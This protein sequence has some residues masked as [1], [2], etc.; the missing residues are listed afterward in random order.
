MTVKKLKIHFFVGVLL[1]GLIHAWLL[2]NVLD[3]DGL[4]NLDMGDGF[5]QGDRKA[6]INGMWSP[7]YPILLGF[8]M[9]LFK[10]DTYWESTVVHFVNFLIYLLS[11]F[12][13][14]FFLSQ[15]IK[16]Q[17]ARNTNVLPEWL[18]I[19]F[20]YVLFLWSSLSL[21]TVSRIMPDMLV[22]A[23]VYLIFGILLK[24]KQE[25][26]NYST[27]IL[28]GLVLGLGYLSKSSMF[29]FAFI[30]LI[31]CLFEAKDHSRRVKYTFISFVVFC[32]VSSPYIFLL[33]KYKGH[34][35]PGESGKVNY[36]WEVNRILEMNEIRDCNMTGFSQCDKLVHPLRELLR[37]PRVMEYSTPFN[38]TYPP[39]HDP[40]YW[41]EGLVPQLDLYGLIQA[42]KRNGK[43]YINLFSQM[44]WI[45][46]AYFILFFMSSNKS[47]CLRNIKNEYTLLVPVFVTVLLYSFIH[48]EPRYVAPFLVVFWLGLFSAVKLPDTNE[49]IKSAHSLMCILIVLMSFV[50]LFSSELWD[51]VCDN[52]A[53]LEWKVSEAIKKEANIKAGDKVAVFPGQGY[54]YWARYAKAR[55]V[56]EIR[57]EDL[58]DFWHATSSVQSD[59]FKKLKDIGVK[60][61]VA[62]I[63][64][65]DTSIPMTSWYKI[66]DTPY[67]YYVL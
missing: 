5:F 10:P 28:F 35:T 19:V 12:S 3:P 61:V 66:K 62:F 18:W 13:F 26:S 15:F 23:L 14:T 38:V 64:P 59:I 45:L 46:F 31:F 32:L 8:V 20:G 22:S 29:I 25:K 7:L 60:I 44:Q 53:Y 1:L 36:L 4:P 65:S 6:V 55:I 67:F 47:Q 52:S 57:Q 41:M 24:I 42:L 49:T 17:K 43:Y 37:E 16:Y 56:A 33:S 50:T 21:I 48:I 9:V 51:N 58:D 54:V 30:F 27:F 63:P 34:F 2:R 11:F 39:W 40:S